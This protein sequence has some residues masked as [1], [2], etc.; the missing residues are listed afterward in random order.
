MILSNTLISFLLVSVISPIYAAPHLDLKRAPEPVTIPIVRRE[1]FEKRDLSPEEWA[2]LAGRIKNK[3][4]PSTGSSRRSL[5][6][7]STTNQQADTSYFGSIQ[8]G[9]PP[10]S[11]NVVLDTGSAD[12]WLSSSSCTRCATQTTGELFTPSDSSTFQTVQGNLDVTYGSG[13]A[14]GTLGSDTVSFGGFQVGGQVFGVATQVTN[15]FL[16]GNLS[17]LMGLGF[18]N[19]ASTGALPWWIAASSSWTKPQMSFYLTRFRNVQGAT[20][21]DEPGGQFTMG[22]TNSSLY[23]GDINFVSLVKAQYWT[24]PL[25]G[26]GVSSGSTIEL[27]GSTANAAIDTGTT[28]IGGPSSV[29]DEFYAQI[30][31]AARGST[32]DS[33]LQDYYVIPCDAN[34]QPTLT[35]GGQTYTM[36]ASDLIGGTVSNSYCLG[37]FF[38]LDL[39]SGSSDPIPGA[40]SQVPTWVIGSAFLKNVYTVFQSDPAAVGFANLKSNVQSIGELGPAGFSIDENGNTNGTIIRS[41]AVRQHSSILLPGGS[42][43]TMALLG[44]FGALFAGVSIW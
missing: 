36:T 7:V 10:K 9:T 42:T 20:N 1:E 14:V 44:L 43:L 34:V 16:T 30:P 27:S 4:A 33:S 23:D 11:Y 13:Q 32:V 26:L 39:S 24:V 41:A 19:L 5:V 6:T 25:S 29:L 28:L 21:A 35:F 37:A 15:S 38:T 40:T 17:G 8:V 31:G 3:F 22:G 12:L 18:Q 2:N